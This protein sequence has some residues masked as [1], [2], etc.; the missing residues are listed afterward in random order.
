MCQEQFLHLCYMNKQSK[1]YKTTLCPCK[2]CFGEHRTS[3]N[4]V[5]YLMTLYSP[6]I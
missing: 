3:T 2:V 4:P 6:D 5:S 1:K